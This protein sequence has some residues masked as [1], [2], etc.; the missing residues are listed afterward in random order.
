MSKAYF[1][2]LTIIL[3]VGASA[4]IGLAQTAIC[5]VKMTVKSEDGVLVKDAVATATS[6]ETEELYQAVLENGMPFF[7][8]LAKGW[9]E[10]SITK[11]GF[12]RSGGGIFVGCRTA[13]EVLELKVS[14]GDGKEVFD[15]TVRRT[16]QGETRELTAEEKKLL[17][18]GSEIN[19]LKLSA[20]LRGILNFDAVYLE[21]PK[22]PSRALKEKVAGVVTVQIAINEKGKVESA[23]AVEGH[24]LLREAAVDAAKKAR[25]N[26]ILKDGKAVKFSGKLVY[27]F[28]NK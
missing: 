24:P 13:T 3:F 27:S 21:K 10:I 7:P 5:A 2:F 18:S 9:Y 26:P 28:T 6:Y 19:R 12:K 17:S 23:E 22:Y 16:V 14:E 1:C 11:V 15:I 20:K 4:S 25:F 8:Q